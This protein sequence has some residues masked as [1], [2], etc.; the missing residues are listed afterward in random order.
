MNKV[1][2]ELASLNATGNGALGGGMNNAGTSTGLNAGLG[3][4]IGVDATNSMGS[5]TSDTLSCSPME[6]SE[7]SYDF[8]A[9]KNTPM[10]TYGSMGTFSAE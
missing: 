1:I 8:T 9:G 2:G 10:S 7:E 3:A 4:D 6:R 5:I